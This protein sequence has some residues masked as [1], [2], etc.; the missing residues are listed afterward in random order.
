MQ[1]RSIETFPSW[2]Q[3]S[4]SFAYPKDLYTSLIECDN[5]GVYDEKTAW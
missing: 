1:Y 3:Q 4:L 5:L 2:H